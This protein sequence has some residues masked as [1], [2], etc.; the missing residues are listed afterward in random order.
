MI[1]IMT[2]IKKRLAK[3]ESRWNRQLRSIG[4]GLKYVLSKLTPVYIIKKYLKA[5]LKLFE[6]FSGGKM[7]E[8]SKRLIKKIIKILENISDSIRRKRIF[9]KRM[10]T[11]LKENIF[12]CI[13]NLKKQNVLSI[14]NA[15][16]QLSK[17]RIPIKNVLFVA[18]VGSIFTGS[19]YMIKYE[20]DMIVNKY[21]NIKEGEIERVNKLTADNSSE[22]GRH[23]VIKRYNRRPAYYRLLERQF[24]IKG[25]ILPAYIYKKGN[26]NVSKVIVDLRIQASNKYIGSFLTKNY[27][28][29]KDI[30][31]TTLQPTDV[32][33]PLSREGNDILKDKIKKEINIFLKK[34]KIEGRVQKVFVDNIING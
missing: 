24:S 27:Y 28:L 19:A 6:I 30:L 2:R 32:Y 23:K 29:L 12:K 20:I 8:T 13:K 22:T 25:L 9:I 7:L 16:K 5:K 4:R 21:N 18:V 15:I 14:L 3:I 33:F 1:M 34:K 10:I 31:Y 17:K 11:G 26:T